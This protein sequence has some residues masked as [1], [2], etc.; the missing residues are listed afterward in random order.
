LRHVV[1]ADH[2]AAVGNVARKPIQENATRGGVFSNSLGRCP[3]VV[4]ASLGVAVLA[5]A[6]KGMLCRLVIRIWHIFP[7]GFLFGMGFDTAQF[8]RLFGACVGRPVC[9]G[10]RIVAST[11][12]GGQSPDTL[13]FSGQPFTA[14]KRWG[15][16]M[17]DP[18]MQRSCLKTIRSQL[19]EPGAVEDPDEP[20]SL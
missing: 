3:V 11:C 8:P 5:P 2:I 20:S 10:T 4:L 9:A 12:E 15:R 16:C 13:I 7:L 14:V 18:N 17:C 6:M 1:D 19:T